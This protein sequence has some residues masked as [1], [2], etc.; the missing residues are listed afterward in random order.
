MKNKEPQNLFF[1]NGINFVKLFVVTI[2]LLIS[3]AIQAEGTPTVSPNSTNITG[4]LVD[5]EYN[6]GPFH[7][8]PTDSRL[9]FHILNNTSEN[10]Y[11]GFDFRE[12]ENSAIPARV[13]NLYY[14]IFRPNG[15]IAASGLWN[16]TFNSTGSIDNYTEAINGPNIGGVTTGYTPIVFNP[17]A[18]GEHWIELYRSN[19]GGVTPINTGGGADAFG[20]LF[21]LTV[22]NNS[23][24]FQKHPGRVYSTKWGFAAANSNLPLFGKS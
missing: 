9:R 13:N 14:R 21:D 3:N 4:L 6:S 1:K 19:N 7:N 2:T 24:T 20:A 18:N 5:P 10:L 22:A 23:G 8:S 11:F 16:S 17:D 12:Y 15:T